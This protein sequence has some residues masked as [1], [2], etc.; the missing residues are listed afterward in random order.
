[1]GWVNA[2]DPP[3]LPGI[4]GHAS[5][6]VSLD[7]SAAQLKLWRGDA[8]AFSL[9]TTLRQYRYPQ[10]AAPQPLTLGQH[11]IALSAQQALRYRLPSG[12][13]HL[14]LTLPAQTLA[15]TS[16]G[17]VVRST[18]YSSAQ[19]QIETL[20]TE[21]DTLWLIPLEAA[22]SS[23]TVGLAPSSP[24]SLGSGSVLRRSFTQAGIWQLE[25]RLPAAEQR[26]GLRLL[27]LGGTVE[28]LTVN[29]KLHDLRLALPTSGTLRLHHAAGNVALWLAGE[30]ESLDPWLSSPMTRLNLNAARS[31]TLDGAAQTLRLEVSKPRLVHLR[32]AMP[33]LVAL[34]APGSPVE[35]RAFPNGLA[36]DI[37]LPQGVSLISLHPLHGE[38]LSGSVHLD[39]QAPTSLSE[40]LGAAVLLP[41]GGNALF[42]LE[43]PQ[44]G[45]LGVGVSADPDQIDTR[46]FSA[47]GT[48]LGTGVIQWHTLPA[49]SYWL[50]L[51][52]PETAQLPILARPAVVGLQLPAKL[53]PADVLRGYLDLARTTP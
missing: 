19:T 25:L 30:S 7:A 29:H 14:T 35:V 17:N 38:S 43:L 24:S 13:L 53:P 52:A 12:A 46:L 28:Y 41:P 6:S 50:E 36:W 3:A 8:E 1:V 37:S 4:S 21:A 32:G 22:A 26:A 44:A 2:T 18:H 33:L 16:L 34:R 49:G 10:P 47:E 11:D 40:G 31:V 15:V 20:D 48:V 5:A 45:P 39:S 42:H 27:S 51:R 9:Q 23:V